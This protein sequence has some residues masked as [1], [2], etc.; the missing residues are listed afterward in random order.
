MKTTLFTF[1]LSVFSIVNS[2]A[3][4]NAA[5]ISLPLATETTVEPVAQKEQVQSFKSI[6]KSIEKKLGRKLKLSERIG[7]WYYTQ[8]PRYDKEYQRKTNNQALTG[9]IL[10]VCSLVIFPLLA[11][12]G[13]ILSNSAL[14]RE[15]IDP[16]ILEGGNRGLAKA[17]QIL[18]II[19]ILY[20]ILVV[21]YIIALIGI[22]TYG[23]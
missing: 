7:L 11:I 14:R 6:R 17:G 9:F 12:P 20:F 5:F 4:G 3:A 15:K 18:S 10:S 8:F 16:G 22:G 19:G 21:V 23:F 2:C 1:I 13:L